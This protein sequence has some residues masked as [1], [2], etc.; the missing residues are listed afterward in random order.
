MSLE[1]LFLYVEAGDLESIKNLPVN[2]LSKSDSVGLRALHI[3]AKNGRTSILEW[4]VDDPQRDNAVNKADED[5]R[6]P[7]HWAAWF[8]QADSVKALLEMGAVRD[9]PTRTGFT[10]LHYVSYASLCTF[11]FPFN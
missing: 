3:A 10:P 11:V 6:C 8:G 5:A 1:Q 7:I 9:R 4:L 2:L